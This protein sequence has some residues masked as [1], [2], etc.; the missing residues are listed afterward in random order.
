MILPQFF[1]ERYD[2]LI[3]TIKNCSNKEIK[4]RLIGSLACDLGKGCISYL[5]RTL[6]C[7]RKTVR[8]AIQFVK[9]NCNKLLKEET[10]GRKKLINKYPE[11]TSDIKNIIKEYLLV[12]PHFKSEKLYVR[13]TIKE[14]KKALVN[15]GKYTDK[16]FSNSS[17]NNILNSLGYNLKKVKKVKP[18][19]KIPETDAIFENVKF[20]KEQALKEENTILI[21][22]DTKDKVLIGPYSRR[23]KSRIQIEAVDHELT[24]NCIV[25]FGIIDIKKNKPYIFNYTSKPTSLDYVDAIEEFYMENYKDTSVNRIAILLDNG[26]D[27]SGIRTTFLFGLVKICKKYNIVIE[28]VYYPPYHSKYNPIE[29]LWAR[30]ENTWN[31]SLLE[32]QDICL[33]FMKNLTWKGNSAVVKL[34]KVKYEKGISISNK[35]MKKLENENILRNDNLKKWSIIITP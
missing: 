1:N 35:E 16:S 32:T 6:N 7:C 14:V 17:L 5:A 4:M 22:L 10:R 21:T 26:P 12:D 3:D 2:N 31:G 33:N 29:R 25:P 30:L 9:N 23:G 11:L 20:R 34:K 24:S 13:L 28:L 27:N 8:K 19:K 18:L 15:T